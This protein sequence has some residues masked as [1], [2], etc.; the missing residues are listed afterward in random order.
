[1]DRFC[2]KQVC[3]SRH[4]SVPKQKEE[5]SIAADVGCPVDESPSNFVVA[6][7][8]DGGSQNGQACEGCEMNGPEERVG[9]VIVV[10]VGGSV[11]IGVESSIA[12]P[13]NDAGSRECVFPS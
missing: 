4:C 11:D 12:G 7:S 13:T 3:S 9:P 6:T 8:V 2:P 1:M 10:L 5:G